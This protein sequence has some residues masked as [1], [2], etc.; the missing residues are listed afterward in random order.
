MSGH[1][2]PKKE[3]AAVVEEAK[4]RAKEA[5]VES[6]FF[7]NGPPTDAEVRRGIVDWSDAITAVNLADRELAEALA[8]K[9]RSRCRAAMNM[10]NVAAHNLNLFLIARGV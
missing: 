8:N 5:V 3:V 2:K 1:M 10:L 6:R 9:D 7:E 4:E